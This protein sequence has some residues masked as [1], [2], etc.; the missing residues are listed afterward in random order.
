MSNKHTQPN[1]KR[2][3]QHHYATGFNLVELV[4]VLAIV[5]V[6]TGLA[7][8]R[9]SGIVVNQRADAA[10]KRVAADLNLARNEAMKTSTTRHVQIRIDLDEL[11]LFNVKPLDNPLG[12]DQKTELDNE[13]YNADIVS[14]LGAATGIAHVY[15]NGYGMPDVAGDIVIQIGDQQRTITLEASNGKAIVQ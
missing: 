11:Q 4:L 9:F 3:P 15:F 8:P 5:A 6:M 2:A 12:N 1:A 13:P 14:A 10:A 7:L